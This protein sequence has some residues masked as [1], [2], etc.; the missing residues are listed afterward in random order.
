MLE[1]SLLFKLGF[2]VLKESE[3]WTIQLFQL[4]SYFHVDTGLGIGGH[5]EDTIPHLEQVN[6]VMEL[7]DIIIIIILTYLIFPLFSNSNLRLT[8]CTYTFDL[9]RA[10][11]NDEKLGTNPAC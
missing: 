6:L 5:N 8:D 9:L 11:I 3:S 10:F 7:E 1:L 4:H 2:R